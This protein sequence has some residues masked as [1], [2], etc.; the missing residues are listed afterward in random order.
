M[1]KCEICKMKVTQKRKLDDNNVCNECKLH[2]NTDIPIGIDDDKC[3]GDIAFGEFKNWMK[4]ELR[5]LVRSIVLEEIEVTT[6]QVDELKK[7]NKTLLTRLQESEKNLQEMAKEMET[8]KVSNKDQK[9]V[10]DN[11][12]KYLI[13]SDRNKRRNNI[14]LFGVQEDENLVIGDKTATSDFEKRE[15]VLE[16][17]GCSDN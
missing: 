5:V 2:S 11:N 12:L 8:M 13:N 3:M 10:S 4:A 17:M 7:E 1:N 6:K 15:L 14:V 9:T 16:H